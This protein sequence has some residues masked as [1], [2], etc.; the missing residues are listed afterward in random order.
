M[1]TPLLVRRA[2]AGQATTVNLV[3][4]DR[5]GEWPTVVGG[6]SSAF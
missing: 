1:R 5:C 2:T 3:V 6:G 4:V